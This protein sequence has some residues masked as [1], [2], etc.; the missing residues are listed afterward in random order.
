[1]IGLMEEIYKKYS[2]TYMG[3][4]AIIVFFVFTIML[5]IDSFLK[6]EITSFYVRLSV[7][8]VVLFIVIAIWIM[9]RNKYPRIPKGKIGIVISL[10]MENDKQR[11][12][13]ENDFVKGLKN[14]LANNE[15]NS[16][17]EI[18]VLDCYQTS[19][20][21][22]ILQG[23]SDK[24]NELLKQNCELKGKLEKE[25]EFKDFR[26]LCKKIGGHF[27]I[28]GSMIE[29][30]DIE[31]TYFLNLSALVKH[32]PIDINVSNEVAKEFKKIFPREISFYEKMEVQSFKFA[33]D[34]IHMAVRYI[35]G[36]AALISGDIIVAYQLHKDLSKEIDKIKPLPPPLKD[37]R[38]KLDQIISI[39]LLQKARLYY[40]IK[41][42]YKETKKL[43]MEAERFNPNDY[44]LLIMDS[45]FYFT[46]ERDP[47]RAI[48]YLKRAKKV[49]F[50]DF[51]WLY[52]KAFLHMYLGK[53][54]KGYKDYRKLAKINHYFGEESIVDQCIEF[55]NKIYN[56]EGREQSLFIIG[57]LYYI[58][59][60]NYP[61]A[62]EYLEKFYN[63]NKNEKQYDFLNKRVVHYIQEIKNKM[64]L[65]N[66]DK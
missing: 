14:A 21:I 11:E 2:R 4:L 47:V 63:K 38:E 10:K 43:L 54:E 28:W 24:K 25:K 23:Y 62:L 37:V 29:R 64:Q 46:I 58:K 41:R 42:D 56:D 20:V 50:N 30:K 66:D 65:I 36:I 40:F 5:P 31:N 48:K 22:K 12:R 49:S 55:N 9:Y 57:L 15:L 19:N 8:L 59:K 1:M 27:Y 44:S 61:M 18:F 34:F 32:K 35:V 7:Y 3:L 16:L 13:I 26:W 60:R 52:N 53:Y 6:D 17:F 33:S 51:T 39:E 45:I